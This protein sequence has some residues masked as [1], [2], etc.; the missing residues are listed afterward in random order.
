MAYLS[1]FYHPSGDLPDKQWKTP[2]FLAI[3]IH[4]LVLLLS[5]MPSSLF[6]RRPPLPEIIT[7]NLF[8]VAEQQPK[9]AE[10]K[11]RQAPKTQAVKPKQI[12]TPPPP[13]EK[14][15]TSISQEI[16]AP[17]PEVMAPEKII[18]LAPTKLK[19]KTPPP[20]E[21]PKRDIKEDKRLKALERIQAQVNK[22]LEDQKTIHDLAKLRESLHVAQPEEKPAPPAEP[23]AESEVEP[24]SQT[25]QDSA[26]SKG[27][28]ELVD[29][30]ANEYYGKV[31]EK[32][33]RH[34]VLPQMQ[35]WDESLE[36]IVVVVIRR[37]GKIIQSYF[38]K[39]S[40]NPYFNQFVEKTIK[41]ATATPLPPFPA[42]L[43]ETLL[44]DGIGLTFH[45]S[46]LY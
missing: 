11:K 33:Q 46:G 40:D 29:K 19:K 12:E 41:E 4:L 43:D 26:P 25:E 18:S 30:V 32:I 38:E 28:A 2:F 39:R 42:D 22:K 23:A 15:V 27:G 45:P 13:P 44:E 35:N 8:N 21:K 34:W 14:P 5:L 24:A 9:K 3:G 31:K 1:N 16:P 7:I 10:P 6:Y 36:A 37:D 17:P 20:L